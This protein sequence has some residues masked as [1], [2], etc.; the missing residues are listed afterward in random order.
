[1]YQALSF[2]FIVILWVMF[3]W[4]WLKIR[5]NNVDKKKLGAVVSSYK[6]LLAF[7][8]IYE[9]LWV[10]TRPYSWVG[11]LQVSDTGSKGWCCTGHHSTALYLQNKAEFNKNT[12]EELHPDLHQRLR[13][14]PEGTGALYYLQSDK[15]DHLHSSS[16]RSVPFLLVHDLALLNATRWN[17]TRSHRSTA[18]RNSGKRWRLD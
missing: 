15:H 18:T 11:C 9:R 5:R 1:M 10:V 12:E 4:L 16:L 7:M 2:I 3:Q 8:S 17:R 14:A 13:E 6:K